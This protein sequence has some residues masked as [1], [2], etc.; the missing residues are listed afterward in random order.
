MCKRYMKK[1]K[2]TESNQP[3]KLLIETILPIYVS[4]S[5]I[6][7]IEELVGKEGKRGVEICDPRGKSFLPMF[8][9][10]WISK[11]TGVASSFYKYLN[12]EISQVGYINL[13]SDLERLG[14]T[15]KN[16][17]NY[18]IVYINPEYYEEYD[19]IDKLVPMIDSILSELDKLYEDNEFHNF[20]Y[21]KFV[22][23]L[24]FMVTQLT[25]IIFN[26]RAVSL[27]DVVP[28]SF[29]FLSFCYMTLIIHW[30]DG[31]S[32]GVNP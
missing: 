22:I 13:Q 3:I 18:N 25:N 26:T 24:P 28:F 8:C 29:I 11:K 30:G 21:E 12:R 2:S 19:D 5:Y 9:L 14:F 31:S 32:T 16:T 6:G 20:F 23:Q 7:F 15:P 10:E 1:I 17:G 4:G 27:R